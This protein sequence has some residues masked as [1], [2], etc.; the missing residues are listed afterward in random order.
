MRIGSSPPPS[1]SGGNWIILVAMVAA[2]GAIVGA[3]FE[4]NRDGAKYTAAFVEDDPLRLLVEQEAMT[5]LDGLLHRF[6]QETGREVERLYRP[7]ADTDGWNVDVEGRPVDA[8][9]QRA[10]EREILLDWEVRLRLPGPAED[11]AGWRLVRPMESPRETSL[12][13]LESWLVAEAGAT[14]IEG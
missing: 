10:S 2:F 14:R 4:L 1:G 6:A 3:I 7:L 9:I 8:M 5:S 12:Q 13:A 11:H